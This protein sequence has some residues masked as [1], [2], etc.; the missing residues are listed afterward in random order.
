MREGVEREKEEAMRDV[1]KA[2][3]EEEATREGRKVKIE[4]R[5]RKREKERR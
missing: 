4:R 2:K 1:R 3:R 5:M